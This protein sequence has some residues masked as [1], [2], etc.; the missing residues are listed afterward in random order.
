MAYVCLI[1]TSFRYVPYVACVGLVALDGNP[2]LVRSVADVL[3]AT[4]FGPTRSPQ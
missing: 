1:M 3:Y 2:A 4:C